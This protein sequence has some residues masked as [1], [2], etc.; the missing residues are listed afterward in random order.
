MTHGRHI[1]VKA[2]YMEKAAMCAYPHSNH[3]LSQCKCVLQCCDSCPCINLTD[4]ETD[5]Q[6]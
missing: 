5:N 3:A 6:Y 1:Y 2:S 4:Q